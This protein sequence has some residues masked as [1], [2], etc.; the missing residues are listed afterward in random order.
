MSVIPD[1]YTRRARLHPVV[2]LALPVALAITSMVGGVLFDT[3][4]TV[5]KLLSGGMLAGLIVGA[6]LTLAN[7]VGRAGRK[8]EPYLFHI[9]GGPPLAV[10]INGR[11]EEEHRT[12]W[13]R[14]RSYLSDKIGVNTDVNEDMPEDRCRDLE[15]ELKSLTRDTK[16]FRRVFDENCNYGFRRNM[17]G[18][19][20]WGIGSALVSV[21]IASLILFA[22][23]GKPVWPVLPWSTLLVS[24]MALVGW[25]Y[26]TPV[27][28]R[29]MAD[30]YVS[31]MRDAGVILARDERELAAAAQKNKTKD[32]A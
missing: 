5:G 10:A 22:D 4:E 6:L 20:T 28:V 8:H 27:W 31:A 15:T 25:W 24:L 12:T 13:R 9:W 32:T 29:F 1:E 18:L 2:L 17:F 16:K 14:I 21:V 26:V 23:F 30:A 3:F 11:G 19:K 7:Q